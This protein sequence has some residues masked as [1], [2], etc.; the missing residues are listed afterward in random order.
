MRA[1]RIIACADRSW[2]YRDLV[3]QV[4]PLV[5]VIAEGYLSREPAGYTNVVK[6]HEAEVVDVPCDCGNC[7]NVPKN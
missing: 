7:S 6:A 3:G 4:V 5:R 2:W 1:L